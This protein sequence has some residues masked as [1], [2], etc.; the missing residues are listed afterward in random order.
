MVGHGGQ[1]AGRDA[2]TKIDFRHCG[3]VRNESRRQAAWFVAALG[4]GPVSLMPRTGIGR[5]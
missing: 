2:G 1:T 4:H 3:T 5:R